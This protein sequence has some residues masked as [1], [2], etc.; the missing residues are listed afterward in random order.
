[1]KNFKSNKTLMFASVFLVLLII[2]AFG[3]SFISRTIMNQNS[4]YATVFQ[5][6]GL[7]FPAI[8]YFISTQ[9]FIVFAHKSSFPRIAK[10]SIYFI[11]TIAALYQIW[12]NVKIALYYTV[13]SLNNLQ[14]NLPVG[15][16]N[17]DGNFEVIFPNWYTPALFIITIT[18][19]LLGSYLCY[20]WLM[21]LTPVRLKQLVIISLGG[22]VAFYVAN[23]MVE[24]LKELW[25]RYR[26]YELLSNWNKFTPWWKI[27]GV[28]GHK[29]FPSGHS[30]YGWMALYLV[31]FID[32]NNN[33]FRQRMTILASI[34]GILM[35]FSRIRIGAHFLSDVTVG[36]LISIVVIYTISY[37]VQ[38]TSLQKKDLS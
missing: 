34:F 15:A 35:A 22:I 12:Q 4:V 36:S 9:V 20:S 11:S 8:I 5:N 26:P 14:H 24:S 1:M 28:T 25:G 37:L 19:F 6:Y 31:L 7:I 27:N 38:P 23:T 18:F 29:S 10:I 13:T 17:N 2:S 33:K 30:E 21:K 16:A 3:D 32:L